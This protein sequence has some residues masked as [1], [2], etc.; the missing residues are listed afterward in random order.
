VF[1]ACFNNDLQG[2]TAA[3]F[4]DNTLKAKNVA[5]LQDN[6]SDY[7]TGLASAFKKAFKGSVVSKQSFAEGDKDFNALLTNIKSK[8]IDAIYVPGYYSEVGLIIKQARQ[9]GI[10]V[11][12]IGSDGMAD[13]KLRK[14]PVLTK[15]KQDLLH[16]TIF[17]DVWCYQQNCQEIHGRLQSG[18]R[19]RCANLLCFSL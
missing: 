15:R 8:N 18:L 1:R 5:I 13:P 19:P 11:P 10:N 12:I 14:S 7:G 2:E 6:S 4:A 16:H 9:A 3:H 17:H